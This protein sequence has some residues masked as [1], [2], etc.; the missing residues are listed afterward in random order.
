[1]PM[2]HCVLP[3]PL[4]RD[5][6]RSENERTMHVDALME[7]SRDRGS[8]PRASSLRSPPGERRLPRRSG[9][10]AKPGSNTNS[11]AANYAPAS[12]LCICSPTSIY[13]HGVAAPPRSR[14]PTPTVPRRTTPRQAIYAYVHLRLYTTERSGPAPKPGSNTNSTAANYASASHLLLAF[15]YAPQPLLSGHSHSVVICII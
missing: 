4:R 7:T 11:T 9:P 2:K 3:R 10:A 15:R 8:I 12:H 5:A 13:C 6:P 1:M 14:A